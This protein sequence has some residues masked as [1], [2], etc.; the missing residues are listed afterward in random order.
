MHVVLAGMQ[1]RAELTKVWECHALM[2]KVDRKNL[3][4]HTLRTRKLGRLLD[5]T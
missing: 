1:F 2:L 4:I 5:G 3:N